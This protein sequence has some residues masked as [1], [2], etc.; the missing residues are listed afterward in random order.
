MR[1]DEMCWPGG[2]APDGSEGDVKW[3]HHHTA[4]IH[5]D[6]I[7]D[8]HRITAVEE[9]VFIKWGIGVL[10]GFWA[11]E[12]RVCVFPFPY[13]IYKLLRQ[14]ISQAACVGGI[15]LNRISRGK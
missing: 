15:R 7:Y 2:T 10:P 4:G 14:Q 3:H 11:T 8:R 12:K 1:E 5:I 9:S 13:V 6:S